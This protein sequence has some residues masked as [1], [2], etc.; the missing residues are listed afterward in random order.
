[1]PALNDTKHEAFAQ[2]CARGARF[3]D[4]Y[5]DAGFAP[6]N[7]RASRLARR[8]EV[9]AR[10]AELRQTRAAAEDSDPQTIIDALM[11]MAR[12]SETLKTP[13]GV[14]EARINMLEAHRL[15]E[16]IETNRKDDR[17]LIAIS[18]RP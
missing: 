17:C 15:R 12:D 2:A 11:R 14:K 6:D 10:I 1:M 7:S 16:A 5:Q 3:M 4:A 18:A 13:A 9:A 8:D